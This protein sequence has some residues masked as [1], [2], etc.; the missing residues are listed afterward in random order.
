[1]LVSLLYDSDILE[2]NSVQKMKLSLSQNKRFTK[3]ES[4]V[5]EHLLSELERQQEM[6]QLGNTHHFFMGRDDEMP[7]FIFNEVN[8]F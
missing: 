3:R 7:I 8:I 2:S 6:P 1:M 5:E 4:A